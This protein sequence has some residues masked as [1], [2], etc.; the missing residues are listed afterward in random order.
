M[1]CNLCSTDGNNELVVWN[2]CTGQT[3]NI[4][5][6]TLYNYEDKYAIGYSRCSSSGHSYKILRYWYYEND[7]KEWIAVCKIYDLSYDSWRVHDSLPLDHSIY[8]SGMSL[9]GDTYWVAADDETPLFLMKFDFTAERLVRIH[10]PFHSIGS[11]D[12]ETLSVVKDEKLSVLQINERS[13]VMR[14]WVSNKIDDDE[15]KDFSWRSYLVLEMDSAEFH[16]PSVE[17]FLLNE[18]NKVAVC[19]GS[20]HTGDGDRTIV[21][22]VGED[23]YEQVYEDT[24]KPYHR[25]VP[26]VLTYLPSLVLIQPK[27]HK[28]RRLSDT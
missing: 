7:Q 3:R 19:C 9:K 24:T 21:Y 28:R 16:L 26:A 13:R 20:R 4:K 12:I 14:I 18:E 2:P 27:S 8:F 15:A 17:S 23:M 10:L 22:I 6:R 1:L 5:P 11:G 25:N